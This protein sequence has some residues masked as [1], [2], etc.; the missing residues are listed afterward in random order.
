MIDIHKCIIYG[1][2]NYICILKM[3]ICIF[4]LTRHIT[5]VMLIFFIQEK[6]KGSGF[7]RS[8]EVFG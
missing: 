3:F 4:L 7:G 2:Y 6:Y 1:H 5:Y 8:Y